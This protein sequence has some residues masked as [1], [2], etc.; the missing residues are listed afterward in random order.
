VPIITHTQEG[1]MGPQQAEFLLNLGVPAN[2]IMIGH[3]D[4]NTDITYHQK[5]LDTGVRIA[6]DRCG[7]QY[8][9]KAPS[10][11]ERV[12][13]FAALIKSGYVDRLHLSHDFILHMLGRPIPKNPKAAKLLERYYIG[14]I[15]DH[16]IPDLIQAGV[17]PIQIAQIMEQNPRDIFS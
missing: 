2:K 8:I 17:S 4:G 1:T 3:M 11:Q 12:K 6:F 5:T 16:I 10:D 15:F 13:L 9:L 7:L 14:N